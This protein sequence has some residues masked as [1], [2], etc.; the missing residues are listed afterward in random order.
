MA[1][2][3]SFT[4]R[5]SRCFDYITWVLLSC[6]CRPRTRWKCQCTLH[7]LFACVYARIVLYFLVFWLGYSRRKVLARTFHDMREVLP[8]P[9]VT[10]LLCLL[11]AI[12]AQN[13][14][15][16]ALSIVQSR[17]CVGGDNLQIT[18]NFARQF[19]V[20]FADEPLWNLA[21]IYPEGGGGGGG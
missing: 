14:S 10:N 6:C 3:T 12:S 19:Q 9:L 17:N 20:T 7:L 18:F 8:Y 2:L 21:W 5:R 1:V 4:P 13:D 16:S 15:L 11:A